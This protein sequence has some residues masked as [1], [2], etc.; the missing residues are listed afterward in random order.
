MSI[1]RAKRIK[2]FFV[3]L[4]VCG[5]GPAIPALF[6][7]ALLEWFDA[8]Y[9]KPVRDFLAHEEEVENIWPIERRH[10]CFAATTTRRGDTREL[11]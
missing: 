3:I 2:A 5:V 4:A 1:N 7:Y 6:C 11:I 10:I 8:T 9:D